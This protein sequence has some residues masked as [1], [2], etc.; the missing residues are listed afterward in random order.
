MKKIEIKNKQTNKQIRQVSQSKNIIN[1][2][3]QKMS[4]VFL[5]P[6]NIEKSLCFF[7]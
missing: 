1:G 6:L 5:S 7:F 4:Y 2:M 3:K